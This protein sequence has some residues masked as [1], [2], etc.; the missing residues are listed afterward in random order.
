MS[1]WSAYDS[2]KG[3]LLQNGGRVGAGVWGLGCY[4]PQLRS[5]Y[6]SLRHTIGG[7]A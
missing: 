7:A 4:S 2:F 6:K 3:R 5:G 1:Y